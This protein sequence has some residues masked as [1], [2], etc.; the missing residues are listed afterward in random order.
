MISVSPWSGV[1]VAAGLLVSGCAAVDTVREP[2]IAPS[3]R[4]TMPEA[5]PEAPLAAVSILPPPGQLRPDPGELVGMTGGEVAELLGRPGLL[6][7][8]P[9]AEVWRYAGPSCVLHI[10][11]YPDD[12]GPDYRVTFY[13]TLGPDAGPADSVSCY[14]SLIPDA[15]EK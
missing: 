9:P 3:P 11:L 10:F 8:E 13:E 1:V 14:G 7:R 12:A 6:R 5:A 2:E 15:G 4:F